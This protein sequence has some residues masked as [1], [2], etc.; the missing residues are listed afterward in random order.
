MIIT[1]G[2]VFPAE[3]YTLSAVSNIVLLDNIPI[4]YI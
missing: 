2:Y 3:F 1:E 4:I